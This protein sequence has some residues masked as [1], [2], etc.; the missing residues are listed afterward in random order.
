MAK[1]R[2]LPAQIQHRKVEGLERLLAFSEGRKKE[3]A[4]SLAQFASTALL[5]STASRSVASGSDAL[6][7]KGIEEFREWVLDGFTRM[8]DAKRWQISSR[9]LGD[10]II[11]PGNGR[12]IVDPTGN[13][14]LRLAVLELLMHEDWRVGRCAYPPCGNL[15][16]RKKAGLFCSLKCSQIARQIRRFDPERAR[17]LE[18]LKPA[19]PS[20]L[21]QLV[22][23]ENL[24]RAECPAHLDVD[25]H[26][27]EGLQH[28]M[29]PSGR[30]LCLPQSPD[31]EKHP[32]TRGQELLATA[33]TAKKERDHAMANEELKSRKR[34]T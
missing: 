13:A 21:K 26:D 28:R 5:G 24:F 15:F 8:A 12:R 7:N 29:A 22:D 16:I 25:L 23:A 34:S 19:P 1:H 3:T 20:P 33:R 4:I 27:N 10:Y 30:V 9:E 31:R 11:E 17:N 14:L 32:P 6:D 18:N 2:E